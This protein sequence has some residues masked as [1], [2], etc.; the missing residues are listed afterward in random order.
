[1]LLVSIVVVAGEKRNARASSADVST[2]SGDSVQ[3]E[4]KRESRSEVITDAGHDGTTNP[5]DGQVN[6]AI[7]AVSEIRV[8]GGHKADV[9]RLWELSRRMPELVESS[10]FLFR[11]DGEH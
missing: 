5:A 11:D 2:E 1:V 3:S 7:V 4:E 9:S 6:D 8:G 10:P